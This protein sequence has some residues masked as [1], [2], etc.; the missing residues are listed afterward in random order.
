MTDEVE[1]ELVEDVDIDE[2][3]LVA[4][5]ESE[6]IMMARA[7]VQ[8]R[9][10]DTWAYLA[11][12]H[13]MPDT[14]GPSCEALLEDA[15][16]RIWPALWRRDGARPRASVIGN[17]VVRGRPWQRYA[18]APLVFTR[19]TLELLRWLVGMP[20]AT[21]GDVPELEARP[22][23]IGD[24]VAIY[25]ALDLATD[26]PPQLV[27]ARQPMVRKSAL[28]WLGFAHLMAGDA[29]DFTPIVTGVG[30]IVVDALGGELADR[31]RGAEL[32]K[33]QLENPDELLAVGRAQSAALEK[34]M[35]AC[36]AAHRR[37]LA[38]FVL[39]AARPLLER[40]LAP[41]AQLL[42]PGKPL[43][44]RSQARLAAGALLR[45]VQTWSH[46]DDQHRGVRF[47]DDDYD[48]AQILLG[49]FEPIG[50]PLTDRAAQ[51]LSELA[52]L[53]PTPSTTI[54]AP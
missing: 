25:L 14:I 47:I 2:V 31:W 30:A 11:S 18:P 41:V 44:T 37:D 4:Q 21:G 48:V 43:S 6:L 26:L 42:D 22:L 39:D 9:A 35:A 1:L 46:W 16:S 7:L 50:R 3:P 20:L 49:R 13:K 34:F 15:L 33:R 8:P 5:S 29:P 51:M 53:I 17:A 54:E 12:A 40:N 24:E 28:A 32:H 36:D 23:A 10:H 52:S 45:G 19:A 27:I 38:S